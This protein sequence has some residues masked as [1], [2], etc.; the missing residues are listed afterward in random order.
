MCY[1]I[2]ENVIMLGPDFIPVSSN[3]QGY[4]T[5]I[6]GAD[7][8][9]ALVLSLGFI[10]YFNKYCGILCAGILRFVVWKWFKVQVSME[11]VAISL[12]GG[13]VSFKNLTII[14][15]DQTINMID[16]SF[17]WQYW[18]FQRM[19]RAEYFIKEQ[20]DAT[21]L[22][23][24]NSKLPTRFNVTIDGLEIFVYNRVGAYEDVLLQL[25]CHRKDSGESDNTS[26]EKEDMSQ[27]IRHRKSNSQYLNGSMSES[28][29]I[30]E[31]TSQA[32]N[33][34]SSTPSSVKVKQWSDHFL[35]KC[36][37]KF[38]P[39]S[40]KVRKGAFVIGNST[41]PT[42]LVASYNFANG[43]IDITKAPCFLDT[44]RMFTPLNFD[45]LKLA[46]KPNL[47]YDK[48]K[49]LEN[50]K[51]N[52]INPKENKNGKKFLDKYIHY[53]KFYKALKSLRAMMKHRSSSKE[54]NDRYANWKGLRRYVDEFAEEQ[55]ILSNMGA[56]DEYAKYSQIFDSSF[57]KLTYYQD[58]VGSNPSNG[59]PA[60]LF[61]LDDPKSGA[62]IEI[63]GAT[64]H[65]GP[66]A[67]KQ[68]NPLQSMFFPSLACDAKPDK[69][70]KEPG[71]K[72]KY[73][74]FNVKIFVKDE[75]VFR[76]PT[77]EPSKHREH[78]VPTEATSKKI[79]RPFGWLA[80]SMKDGSFLEYFASS[81]ADKDGWKNFLKAKFLSPEI[82][83]S[84]NHDVFF[85]A[86]KHDMSCEINY[87]L[88]WN[89]QCDWAIKNIS[90]QGRIFF[91]REHT[92]LI[93]DI[94]SDFG[95][96][97]PTSYEYLR[98]FFYGVNWTFCGYKLYLNVNENNI[99]NN[100]LDFTSNQY[101]S[102]QGD[103]LTVDASLPLWGPISKSNKVGY[104][105]YSPLT[106]FV[107][108][109]PPWHTTHTFMKSNFIGKSMHFTIEGY[110]H[111]FLQVE[112]NTSNYNVINVLGD[113]FSILFYGFV[114]KYLFV[115][116]ENYIGDNKHFKTFE[117]Y[118]NEL[119]KEKN[120]ISS[121]KNEKSGEV[122]YKKIVKTE[123]DDDILFTVRVK[124]GLIVL[125]VL[126]YDDSSHL[127]LNF[128][129]FDFDM[130][131]TNYYSD[132]QGTFSPISA[133]YC[134]DG[135][136]SLSNFGYSVDEDKY[137]NLFDVTSSC[138]MHIDGFNIHS[139]RMF[140]LPPQELTYYS[141][142]DL[143]S[144]AITIDSDG[145][146]LK[147]FVAAMEKFIFGFQDI[148]NSLDLGQPLIPDAQNFAF[149]C[150]FIGVKL[151]SNETAK[152]RYA[153][154]DIKNV[155]VG[156]NDIVNRRYSDRITFL[157]PQIIMKIVDENL[158][159]G[160][161]GYFET[162][163]I[164]DNFCQ[165]E[166]FYE[167]KV[168][169]ENFI[170]RNDAPFHRCPFILEEKYRDDVYN[171][172]LGCFLTSL[173]LVDAS[174]PLNDFT[175]KIKKIFLDSTNQ[176]GTKTTSNEPYSR[177][178]EEETGLKF[179]PTTEYE[180]NNFTP[181][182][183]PDPK[184]KYDSMIIDLVEGKAFITPEAL[185]FLVS[186][187]RSMDIHS[188]ESWMDALQVDIVGILKL[189]VLS[190]CFVKN[191]RFITKELFVVFSDRP[192]DIPD[193]MFNN[194]AKD[195]CPII[196]S[197]KEPSLV[198]SQA[199][200]I[201]RDWPNLNKSVTCS[202]AI[203]IPKVDIMAKRP[204][205]ESNMKVS[206][207]EIE[208]W[209][210][211]DDTNGLVLSTNLH[212]VSLHS[213]LIEKEISF[214][215]IV[216]TIERILEALTDLKYIIDSNRKRLE[217][218]VYQ[219]TIAGQNFHVDHDPAVLTRP[220]YILRSRQDHVRYLDG[221]K[222]L[223][224]LR[225]ILRNLPDEWVKEKSS[226]LSSNHFKTPLDAY[227][228]V[229]DK[230]TEWRSWELQRSQLEV[231]F[232][233]IFRKKQPFDI[234]K[235]EESNINFVLDK[236]K[237]NFT[238][239]DNKFDYVESNQLILSNSVTSVKN[240]LT[241]RRN[242]NV[243]SL[244]N[245]K[246]IFSV[247]FLK[248][249]ISTQLLNLWKLKDLFLPLQP[250]FEKLFSEDTDD[251][252]SSSTYDL[253]FMCNVSVIQQ[254]IE[255]P[256]SLVRIKGE[257]MLTSCRLFETTS[258]EEKSPL[259]CSNEISYVS[260]ELLGDYVSCFRFDI[261]ELSV[262]FA[263]FC[264]A[265]NSIKVVDLGILKSSCSLVG[266]IEHLLKYLE[267]VYDKDLPF[268][269]EHFLSNYDDDNVIMHERNN[270]TK[271]RNIPGS[272]LDDFA[273]DVRLSEFNFEAEFFNSFGIIFTLMENKFSWNYGNGISALESFFHEFEIKIHE[274]GTT[275]A[276]LL[277]SQILNEVKTGKVFDLDTCSLTSSIGCTKL[278]IPQIALLANSIMM[279]GQELRRKMEKLS[280][281][282]E[283]IASR[284]TST[285]VS[286]LQDSNK[287]R[288]L[289]F[290]FR[291]TDDYVCFSTSVEES[292]ATL[293]MEGVSSGVYNVSTFKG[294]DSFPVPLHGDFLLPSLRFSFSDKNIPSNLSEVLN[295]SIQIKVINELNG[296]NGER[297]LQIESQHF[298]LCLSPQVLFKAFIFAD[299]IRGNLI[300]S[301]QNVFLEE[302]KEISTSASDESSFTALPFITIHVFCDNFCV[303]WLFE[304]S[305][306]NYPGIMIGAQRF[307]AVKKEGLGKF[308]LIDAY[309]SVA[310][311]ASLSN[312]YGFP[313]ECR[314]MNYGYLPTV[315]L[316]Y[317]TEAS[318]A[319]KKK[320]LSL[321]GD[322]IDIKLA[323]D[324]IVLTEN[325]IDSFTQVKGIF[326]QKF[327]ES[328][329]Y[330]V[331][332]SDSQGLYIEKMRSSFPS[333]ALFASLSGCT[334]SLF[335]IDEESNT[336]LYPVASLDSPSLQLAASYIF[337]GARVRK[338]TIKADI[339]ISPSE[340]ILYAPCAAVVKGIFEDLKTRIYKN[341][342]GIA[343]SNKSVES[344]SESF[345][346]RGF[347]S[348]MNIHLG[349]KI[350]KQNLTLS[351][352]PL[353]KVE[354]VVGIG[355]ISIQFN[356]PENDNSVANASVKLDSISAF[357]RHVYSREISGFFELN[358][359]LLTSFAQSGTPLC[360]SSSGLV[361][362][363]SASINV[364]QFKVLNLFKDIWL[365]ESNYSH[366]NESAIA[367]ES[368]SNIDKIMGLRGASTN[369]SRPWNL[370]FI[371]SNV[372]LNL[373][374][375]Q[376]LGKL[377]L[378]FDN[379][380]LSSQK[381]NSL[382][383]DLKI[384]F[385]SVSLVS[386]GRLSGYFKAKKIFFHAALSW[387]IGPDIL[388]IPLMFISMNMD[389]AQLKL[390]FDYHVFAFFSLKGYSVDI[391]NQK[392]GANNSE[393]HL[394]VVIA[395][396]STQLYFTSLAVSNLMDIENAIQ[397]M[398]RENK[399]SYKESLKKTNEE[400]A[401]SFA[402]QKTSKSAPSFKKMKVKMDA[403]IGEFLVQIYPASMSD[404]KVLV[405]RLDKSVAKFKQSEAPDGLYNRL[406]VLFNDVNVRLSK[407]HF[408]TDDYIL[409]CNVDE[410][411]AHANEASGGTIFVFPSFKVAM[412]TFQEYG[413]NMVEYLFN[414]LFSGDVFI[415]WNLGS[416]NFIREMYSIHN[417]ALS[418][419]IEYRKVR[420]V[421][422]KRHRSYR[423]R[424]SSVKNTETE[425][426]VGV[427]DVLSLKV[428]KFSQRQKYE[429]RA[430]EPP[431]IQAPYIKELGNATPPLE[432][433]GLHRNKFPNATHEYGIASL[434]KLSQE[435]EALY[436]KVLGK[437]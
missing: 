119:A 23:L 99:I 429:Y 370:V 135:S 271:P 391:Y 405:V 336:S 243:D 274:K 190:P 433:F 31:F 64:V 378:I 113:Y 150:P 397:R 55:D 389:Q 334:F 206:F 401:S 216:Y 227:Q 303:G 357:L 124:Q 197:I 115:I 373:D 312:F 237:M 121:S 59:T 270:G 294:R 204:C 126:L 50:E 279:Y 261:L 315:Q 200:E 129:N 118:N 374:C 110:Y 152:S 409:T 280:S 342:P 92:T 78:I 198:F 108:E 221:W 302:R 351:C 212:A 8:T 201:T 423:S 211:R 27:N 137:K 338:H 426:K 143:G 148:E 43:T 399:V 256:Y 289:I 284:S 305:P 33:S 94:F 313:L 130:R 85:V 199:V 236:F 347:I 301:F 287:G 428:D 214:H 239:G 255:L 308:S 86:D 343:S 232:N 73:G 396:D 316:T 265:D 48:F 365:P 97:V 422:P 116:R 120:R 223:T 395:F 353:A 6:Y 38:L 53:F 220:A 381:T 154:F 345:D 275:I 251:Q 219:V 131:F 106:N 286:K 61:N 20:D 333:I 189:I 264:S 96:G 98:P 339:S 364:K 424:A 117:E 225:H 283:L 382:T 163:F 159:D 282:L 40:M 24:S 146:F 355:G 304:N 60:D 39:M 277:N 434:Q 71:M 430:L 376:S 269:T 309:L 70:H 34:K 359:V 248:F 371:I 141:K 185:L 346:I 54:E 354:A 435:A 35:M 51:S 138:D 332:S 262:F 178:P 164:F 158:S 403:I 320:H 104:K 321:N 157:A 362:G 414:C 194:D 13:R 176:K 327:E 307:F 375:G 28:W 252:G 56:Y 37:L 240:H 413:S 367:S 235:S 408:V 222:I 229:L 172:A 180:E 425:S 245:N 5:L 26:G 111:Y 418:S 12:L 155:V 203:H 410:F 246:I 140:G 244:P 79:F 109:T 319:L 89:G 257:D 390:A 175:Q 324:S 427:N 19:R 402:S 36:L 314:K 46:L 142:W 242:V 66:W 437:A 122:D 75:L 349:C 2:D 238:M 30:D 344:N 415:R 326:Q 318:S 10:F 42:I 337:D 249:K 379:I 260:I 63:T 215:H 310:N 290:K 90:E 83:S 44:Y 153:S 288:P 356:T 361:D 22:E 253:N 412:S 329:Q 231:V 32:S 407:L 183:K 311:G 285:K 293:E 174:P 360:I 101:I 47:T 196:M 77:R 386:E 306:K 49:Y 69:S 100:P 340:N 57:T 419:R 187:V 15:V 170:K 182:N 385:N 268:L 139:H 372:N 296:G 67:E 217:E 11:S 133:N 125:P 171:D 192:I 93:S 387:K 400:G 91:L 383:Q 134:D 3:S 350:K 95:S 317:I 14:T 388:D 272:S 369:Y 136:C 168:Y 323:S 352:E 254:D 107:L 208:A 393:D 241:K 166:N 276:R 145:P 65:Y 62:D 74:G 341:N 52:Y 128:D 335:D 420:L 224:R 76:I 202:S 207:E 384:G 68:R 325:L 366:V 432:W 331:N 151:R 295:F 165:N 84:V 322:I 81:L 330:N 191:L 411:V 417:K 406:E 127:K 184:Y 161:L 421:D 144:E 87:P 250:K 278:E 258:S 179:Y 193:K 380:W 210:T 17:V 147:S 80:L 156:F 358:T 195:Y 348:D 29:P 416:I 298:R 9:L 169:K 291:F 102:F 234:G 394:F 281:V 267:N 173:T 259:T 103:N 1:V 226:M 218:L 404:N 228:V 58:F 105:I 114:I 392:N 160:L 209:M 247:E 299:E 18:L 88:K 149:K 16:V 112:I 213:C 233:Y 186:V 263:N 273:V 377:N 431:V 300:K 368:D 4:S 328:V 398:I 266:G 177:A 72:R 21:D 123:N 230:F 188:M 25:R 292:K 132:M 436:Y 45:K 41:T 181:S 205:E 167:R 363:I 297:S 7:W 82:R 162:S